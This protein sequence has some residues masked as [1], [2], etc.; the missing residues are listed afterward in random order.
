[1]GK[2]SVPDLPTSDDVLPDN[3]QIQALKQLVGKTGHAKCLMLPSGAVSIDGRTVNALSEGMAIE[4]GQRVKVIEVR[5]NRVVVRPVE[6]ARGP[7]DVA[8]RRPDDPL[9]RPIEELGLDP[10]D[11][12][13]A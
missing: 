10:L 1:M 5:G 12:P 7:N 6:E 8:R 3:E 11:D 4:A 13:L 2:R 9:S